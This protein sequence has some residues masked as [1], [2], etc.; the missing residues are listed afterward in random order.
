MPRRTGKGHSPYLVAASNA[1]RVLFDLGILDELPHAGGPVPFADRLAQVRPPIRTAMIAYL[2][3][4]RVTCRSTTMSAIAT[5]HK[6]FGELLAGIDPDLD[7]VAA[8][9][10]RKHIKP[11][12]TGMVD[13]LNTK[14]VESVTVADRLRRVLEL[15][16][17]LTDIT[18]W[19][20]ARSTTA[21]AAGPGQ[22]PQATANTAPL[23]PV[24]IDSRLTQ[25][26]TDSLGNELI[27]ANLRLQRSCGLRIGELLDLEPGLPPRTPRPQQRAEGLPGKLDT[28]RM[29]PLDEEILEL[30][31]K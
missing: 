15:M 16:G 21:Q 12:L 2:E 29:V 18:E 22:H 1:Q 14:Y 7:S 9:D 8:L 10:R 13:V 24:D 30:G 27:A 31:E 19:D 3:R 23:P 6:H 4:K 25:I 28:G 26:L 17:F 11:Y 20:L 5:R